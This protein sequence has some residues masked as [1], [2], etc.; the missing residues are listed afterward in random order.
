[1]MTARPPTGDLRIAETAAWRPRPTT[2]PAVK[3]RR[4]QPHRNTAGTVVGFLSTETPSGL[5]INDCK[6]M[7]GPAGRHWIA[8]PAIKQL[9][10]D[11]NPKLDANGKQAWSPVVEFA[12]RQ[13]RERFQDQVLDALRRQYPEALS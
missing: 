1:M 10:R 8:L 6:L 5:I 12:N 3:I 2:V 9:D 7:I 4:W 11:G 13:A